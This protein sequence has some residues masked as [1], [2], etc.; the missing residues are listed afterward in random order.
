MNHHV[1]DRMLLAA[2]GLWCVVGG[3]GLTAEPAAPAGADWKNLR[4]QAINR[5]R[6]I[7]FNNDGNEPVYLCRSVSKDELLEHRTRGL[8][9]TQ[10]DSIFYCT[11]SS[12]FSLFTHRTQAGQVFGTREGRFTNNLAQAFLEQGVNALRVMVEF[13]HQHGIEV[14]WSMRM[15]DTHDGSRT[16]YGPV[17]F[18]AN[19]LKLQHPEYLIGS[20][21]KPPRYGVWSAVDY[22]LPQIRD[23]AFDYCEE[24]CRNYNVDDIELDFFRH[25]WE[26]VCL[27]QAGEVERSKTPVGRCGI[28][29]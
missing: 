23:L 6:R 5:P 10:V 24:V 19:R 14:F 21:A 29:S 15:N 12:G 1:S 22:G 7:I 2:L 18:R 26:T 20:A 9:G 28:W 16:D 25:A 27:T 3:S 13:G 8:V 17:M 11:W 4:Q